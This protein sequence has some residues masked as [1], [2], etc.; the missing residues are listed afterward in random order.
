[1][2]RKS[3]RGGGRLRT[4]SEGG[5]YRRSGIGFNSPAATASA[6]CLV[7]G[8][9]DRFLVCRIAHPDY[10]VCGL[11]APAA[12]GRSSFNPKSIDSI[13]ECRSKRNDHCRRLR[14]YRRLRCMATAVLVLHR[15]SELPRDV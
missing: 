14:C 4:A 10:Q 6:A 3:A 8:H 7:Q 9:A 15:R 1:M 11:Q 12:W 2:S 5:S 13:R